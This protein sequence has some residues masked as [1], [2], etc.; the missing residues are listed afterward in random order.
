VPQAQLLADSIVSKSTQDVLT[1]S[2]ELDAFRYGSVL[3]ARSLVGVR[4]A[5]DACDGV[6]YVRS[7]THTIETGSWRQK[8]ELVREGLGSTVPVVPV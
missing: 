3:T 6:Y 8:F 7:V 5:G 4:G 2:G 1:A